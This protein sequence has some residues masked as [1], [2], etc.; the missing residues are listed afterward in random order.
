[1]YIRIDFAAFQWL[2]WG[3]SENR[4]RFPTG[5]DISGGVWFKYSRLLTNS[6]YNEGL[7]WSGEK[8]VERVIPD[9]NGVG[10]GLQVSMPKHWIK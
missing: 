3:S 8:L 4:E 7:I 6:R 10:V 1:M 5:K 9:W 2:S